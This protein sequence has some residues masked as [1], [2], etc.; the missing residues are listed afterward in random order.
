M[1]PR[2]HSP[3][4]ATLAMGA[5]TIACCFIPQKLLIILSGTNVVML[6]AGV[7]VAVIAGRINGTTAVGHYRMPLYPLWP[8]AALVGLAGVVFA[9]ILD[10]DSGRP[11]LIVNV[12]VMAISAAYYLFY[13]RRR[14]GWTLRAADGKPLEA[15]AAEG[16][17]GGAE[18][19]MSAPP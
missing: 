12:G 19:L 10:P 13:L 17:A 6:Y 3:W 7:S 5:A 9:N 8:V 4:I 2:F 16:L 14:G 1:H 11:S 18:G 15:L